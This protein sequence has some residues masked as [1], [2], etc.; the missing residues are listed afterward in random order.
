MTAEALVC[1]PAF[2]CE[3][4]LTWTLE[5]LRKPAASRA[6]ATSRLRPMLVKLTCEPARNS[7]TEATDGCLIGSE[8]F[9]VG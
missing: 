1:L 5:G 8:E 2:Y 3:Q 6:D 4:V 7:S 9:C